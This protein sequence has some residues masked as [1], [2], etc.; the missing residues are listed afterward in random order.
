MM[1]R[2]FAD[3][4]DAEGVYYVFDQNQAGSAVAGPFDTLEQAE[5]S[6]AMLN[7]NADDRPDE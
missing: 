7:E 3:R 2:F 5:Q 4:Y 1:K 6:A